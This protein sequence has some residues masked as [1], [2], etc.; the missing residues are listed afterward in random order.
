MTVQ[1]PVYQASA[2]NF[3]QLVLANSDKGPVMVH[4]WAPWAGPCMVLKPLLEKLVREYQGRFLLVEVNTDELKE[5]AGRYGVTSL[6]Y[7]KIFR[8]GKVVHDFRGGQGEAEFRRVLDK[9]TGQ[10]ADPLHVAAIRSFREGRTQEADRL[11]AEVIGARPDEASV[12]LDYAKLLM[13]QKRLQEAEQVLQDFAADAP[14]A[15][16]VRDLLAHVRFSLAAQAAPDRRA[17]QQ[18]VADHPDDLQQRFA[19]AAVCLMEDDV[20]ACLQQLLEMV[21]I[22]PLYDDA[23]ARTGMLAL[24]SMLGDEHPL[25][26]E[27]RKLLIETGRGQG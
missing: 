24:F 16:R 7:L 9:F 26:R 18:T 4:F 14:D 20:E 17:L 27:Y 2:D 5:L 23:L 12:R 8:N 19:L 15:Q 21:R 10:G 25:V 3:H 11:F 22:D 1:T 13:S 6:P